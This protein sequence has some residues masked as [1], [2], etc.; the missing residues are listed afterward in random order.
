MFKKILIANR[1][2]IAARV[3]RTARRMGVETVAVYSEADRDAQHVALADDARLIGPAPARQSYLD[4]QKVIAAAVDSG[5]EAVHPGYGFLS[6]NADFA[7]ACTAAGLIFIGPPA[8]AIRAMG[9]KSEA[10]A[11][12]AGAG[13][14]LVPGYHGA[15][16]SPEVLFAEAADVGYPV[17]IKASAGGGGKGMRVAETPDVFA[18][19]LAG[20]KRESMASFS[21]DRMLIEKYLVR[22]RHVEVQV[23][24]DNHGNCHSLFERDCSIQRRHQKVIEEAPAPGLSP[25]LRKRMG[26]AAVAAAKAIGYSGAGTIEFLLDSRGEFYFMEMNTRLQVEHPVTEFITGL[27]LVE[28]QLRVAS[29]ERLPESWRDLTINGHAIETRIYAEDAANGFL[30]STGL[31]SHLRM[32]EA[33]PHVRI[34]SGIRAGDRITVHYDPMIAKLVVWDKDRTAAVSRMRRALADTA[35]TGVSSNVGFLSRLV[36]LPSFEQAHLD[37]GFIGRHED[38]LLAAPAIDASS[39]A[40]AGLGLLL[41]RRATAERQAAASSDASSPWSRMNG[42]RLNVPARETLRIELDGK[43]VTPTVQHLDRGF[44]FEHEGTGLD[45]DGTLSTEGTL[46]ARIGDRKV[47]GFFWGDG[48]RFD[49][50]SEGQHLH[51]TL[52]DPMGEGGSEAAAG[53][54]TAPMPGIIRAILATPGERVV[55]GT[56]LIIMEAMKMEHTIRAPADGVVDAFNCAEGAMTE[57][58]TVLVSFTPEA[59]S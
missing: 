13:V 28:W 22:P 10:K 9:G 26:E 27:D 35:I 8:S 31:V 15:D 6:E 17:L 16:Q 1:G 37:T 46:D 44:R 47:R 11:L 2:E 49:L 20:A 59:G 19:E 34:D 24:A 57:A 7:D 53:A 43:L 12:M 4:Q 56:A 30:P 3:I 29:G 41:H 18:A 45:I 5:A 40:L 21:D 58:G 50:F 32:P 23:F 38:E 51:I 33:G 39:I 14:P 55:K 36:G 25:D 48:Q 52:P 42:F 54:M